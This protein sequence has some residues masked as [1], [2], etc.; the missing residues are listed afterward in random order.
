[1]NWILGSI[2]TFILIYL[3]SVQLDKSRNKSK[4]KSLMDD[5]GKPKNEKYLDFD[6]I[7]QFFNNYKS[8]KN[9]FQIIS[10]NTW[11]DL[12]MNDVFRFY[13]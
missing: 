8:P 10:D 1:M 6:L 5:W 4:R 12:D 9:V 13:R 11:A 7:T 3:I 2:I